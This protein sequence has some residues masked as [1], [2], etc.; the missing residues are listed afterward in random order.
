LVLLTGSRSGLVLAWA[1]VA[2]VAFGS[3]IA[4]KPWRRQA[5]RA[6]VGVL[7]VAAVLA[8]VPF[9]DGS[10]LE[11]GAL[12]EKVLTDFRVNSFI[13]RVELYSA[14]I[15]RINERPWT[16]WGIQG[17]PGETVSGGRNRYL[18]L[19]THS[20]PLNI[21]Y[22]FGWVGLALLLLAAGL[23]VRRLARHATY[24]PE[25]LPIVVT[26]AALGATALVRTLQWDLNVLWLVAAFLGAS[27]TLLVPRGDSGRGERIAEGVG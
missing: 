2:V 6:V 18:R 12:W 16:G 8:V 15:G 3:A 19:G 11:H 1:V 17:R 26:V 27:H 5:V 24:R 22:R 25:S 9:G 23:Y 21:A 7:L 4:A 14:T 20:E 13:D 10:S